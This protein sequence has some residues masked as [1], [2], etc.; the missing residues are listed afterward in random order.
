MI[1]GTYGHGFIG[2][3]QRYVDLRAL[4]GIELH[5]VDCC[6]IGFG[7][8]EAVGAQRVGISDLEAHLHGTTFLCGGYCK[9]S[10]DKFLILV[11]VLSFGIENARFE[12][13]CG[14]GIGY[15]VGFFALTAV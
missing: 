2:V 11:V 7:H 12:R 5:T 4:A 10:E 9:R 3:A 15:P 1:L 8:S 14:S 13:L 6:H